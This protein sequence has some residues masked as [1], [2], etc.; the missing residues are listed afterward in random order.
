MQSLKWAIWLGLLN[1]FCIN[2]MLYLVWFGWNEKN[3][4][5]TT[6]RPP[7]SLRIL[8]KNLN[9][10]IASGAGRGKKHQ[11]IT[12]TKYYQIVVGHKTCLRMFQWSTP[13]GT[14]NHK[15]TLK[16]I[17][18]WTSKFL[19]KLSKTRVV[20]IFLFQPNLTK[21]KE[22]RGKKYETVST[23]SSLC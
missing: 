19:A 7:L 21:N 6:A 2:S 18:G 23:L 13:T 10:S 12:I 4:N 16:I 5:R 11:S 1:F 8:P 15:F 17:C 14:Q 3:S 20:R 22:M 9:P